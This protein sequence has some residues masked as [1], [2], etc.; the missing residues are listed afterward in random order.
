MD[1][2]E[3]ARG[4]ELHREAQ[5]RAWLALS[6]RERLAWLEEAKRF[7]AL[8]LTAARRRSMSGPNSR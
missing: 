4:F 1:E 3:R 2:T 7:A 5:R 8:A 6:Y